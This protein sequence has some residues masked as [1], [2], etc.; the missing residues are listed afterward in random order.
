MVKTASEVTPEVLTR[1]RV[2]GLADAPAVAAETDLLYSV[3]KARAQWERRDRGDAE[4]E[5]GRN[6]SILFPFLS[7]AS[8]LI[9]LVELVPWAI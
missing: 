3:V 1:F 4:S 5:A 9:Y 2:R 6:L 8:F 7:F